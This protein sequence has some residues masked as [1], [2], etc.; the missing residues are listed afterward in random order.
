MVLINTYFIS[1]IGRESF[2]PEISDNEEEQ[3]PNQ[4]GKAL[5]EVHLDT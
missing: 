2:V 5:F 4:I 3:L 1:F